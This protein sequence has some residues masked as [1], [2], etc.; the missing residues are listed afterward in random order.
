[1]PAAA[2]GQRSPVELLA[3]VQL[4]IEARRREERIHGVLLNHRCVGGVI[5][6]GVEA[7]AGG[8]ALLMLP[9]E[10]H[11]VPRDT[12]LRV[13]LERQASGDETI[14]PAIADL[15]AERDV[16]PGIPVGRCQQVDIVVQD[17]VVAD[18]RHMALV[19][20]DRP[21]DVVQAEARDE[22]AAAA[23]PPYV[24]EDERQPHD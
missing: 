17:E 7:R 6:A 13:A 15:P 10:S 11:G 1:M 14:E 8:K 12:D 20:T 4:R 19:A 23:P 22:N 24:G 18:V 2:D 16:A 21:Y 9:A 3:E 5:D